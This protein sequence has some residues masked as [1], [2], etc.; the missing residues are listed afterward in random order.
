MPTVQ[1]DLRQ[2]ARLHATG[3]LRHLGSRRR[4]RRYRRR[5]RCCAAQGADRQQWN[6]CDH[7]AA[8][9]AWPVGQ[10]RA[11]G[12]PRH[13]GDPRSERP[14]RRGDRCDRQS[15]DGRPPR[16]ATRRSRQDRCSR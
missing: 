5:G 12:R 15:R 3:G 6:G 8:P 10:S 1:F 16:L 13:R 9:R 7:G 2:A 11:G 4:L 14:S